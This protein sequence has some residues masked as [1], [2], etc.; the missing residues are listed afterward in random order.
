MAIST[1][2]TMIKY[3]LMTRVA[4]D[5]YYYYYV[6]SKILIRISDASGATNC[7]T[8]SSKFSVDGAL[9]RRNK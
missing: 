1:S 2:R 7:I 8:V 3:T 9:A 4:K 5:Q 6:R